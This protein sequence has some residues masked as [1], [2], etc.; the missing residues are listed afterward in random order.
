[1]PIQQNEARQQVLNQI[2]ISRQL[3]TLAKS[4]LMQTDCPPE[5]S[6]EDLGTRFAK[7]Q[8]YDKIEH[9]V[10]HPSVDVERQLLQVAGRLSCELAFGHALRNLV[11][12][13]YYMAS[14]PL[15]VV[16]PSQE[17]TTLVP[18][19]SGHSSG[20]RFE[21]L[22]HVLPERVLRSPLFQLLAT[23]RFTDPDLFA[24]DAGLEG[25]HSEVVEA[26]RDAVLCL[27][28]SLYRP[29]VAQLGKAVEGA[30]IELG[31][32]LAKTLPA[33]DPVRQKVEDNMKDDDRSIAKKIT[34][35]RDFYSRR[36]LLGTVIKQ[37]G[38]RP[39]E[40]NSV[41]VWADVVR[42]ARNA[43]HFGA[44]PAVANTYEKV[45]VL[46]LD[47]AKSLSLVYVIKRAADTLARQ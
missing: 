39:E 38:V 33:G 46:F 31:L 47:G 37:A 42:E 19:G 25:A 23:E 9:V 3:V 13:N 43:I 27:R 20:W 16:E 15:R 35:V 36:D 6:P 30:W 5:F 8:G 17:W 4:F 7:G 12:A 41:I 11:S 18:G 28:E 45:V 14:S 22:R 26:V 21:E 32:A 29:A 1:M 44:A 34:D 24:L 40:L 2:R 10:L